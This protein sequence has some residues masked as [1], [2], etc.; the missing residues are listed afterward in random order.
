MRSSQIAYLLC[1]ADRLV[2]RLVYLLC[3][4]DRLAMARIMR[5]VRVWSV[6]VAPSNYREAPAE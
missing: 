2:D 1:L 4:A 3:L 6:V 5:P